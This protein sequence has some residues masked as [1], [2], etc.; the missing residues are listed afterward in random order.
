MID[1]E[2]LAIENGF[3][4]HEADDGECYAEI[5]TLKQFAEAYAA[6]VLEEKEREIAELKAIN[7]ELQFQNN[8]FMKNEIELQAKNRELSAS[9]NDLREALEEITNTDPDE[10]TQ[11]FHSKAEQALAITPAQSLQEHDNEVIERCANDLDRQGFNHAAEA[12]RAL[13][14]KQ[15]GT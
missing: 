2:K 7:M 1:I 6:K 11:W 4:P 12:I 13:K 10:G 15:N 9:I 3:I 5:E 8:L 14:G